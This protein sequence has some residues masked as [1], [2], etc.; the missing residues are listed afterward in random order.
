MATRAQK[1]ARRLRRKQHQGATS[2]GVKKVYFDKK[3]GR[4]LKVPAGEI[5]MNSSGY[6][7]VEVP[8][9]PKPKPRSH[10]KGD[11]YKHGERLDARALN[12]RALRKIGLSDPSE[13]TLR[14][15]SRLAKVFG[16]RDLAAGELV[17]KLDEVVKGRVSGSKKGRAGTSNGGPLTGVFKRMADDP[18][19]REALA[20]ATAPFEDEVGHDESSPTDHGDQAY[21]SRVP[22]DEWEVLAADARRRKRGK[23]GWIKV[24]EEA[25]YELLSDDHDVRERES[26]V[27]K[28]WT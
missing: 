24:L 22:E 12:V 8:R 26:W 9:G 2:T 18:K 14:E 16:S 5:L 17:K 1:R 20:T 19:I 7:V 28:S 10:H 27:S 4:D 11:P 3:T 6:D 23:K 21:A 15:F 13:E 25:G